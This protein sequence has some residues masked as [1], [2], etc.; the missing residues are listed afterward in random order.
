MP[1]PIFFF[2]SDVVH[3][4][5][6]SH[7]FKL[8]CPYCSF[9]FFFLPFKELLVLFSFLAH[10]RASLG[11]I[12]TSASEETYSTYC[13]LSCVDRELYITLS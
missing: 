2:I 1:L 5:N 9:A 11:L 7:H 10:I 3:T 13:A 6:L 8:M 12:T 4:L